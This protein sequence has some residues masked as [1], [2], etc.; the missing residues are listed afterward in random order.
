[1]KTSNSIGENWCKTNRKMQK[2]EEKFIRSVFVL[3]FHQ[4]S[5]ILIL[6]FKHFKKCIGAQKFNQKNYLKFLSMP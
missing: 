6:V 2:C 5:L 3:V 4:F 1:L